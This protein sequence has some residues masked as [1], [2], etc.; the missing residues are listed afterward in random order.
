[1]KLCLIVPMY[2]W[3]F[4]KQ[5]LETKALTTSEPA[6]WSLSQRWKLSL[7]IFHLTDSVFC[8]RCGCRNSLLYFLFTTVL[9][10]EFTESSA[11]CIHYLSVSP[12]QPAQLPL[13]YFEHDRHSCAWD[14]PGWLSWCSKS[15]SLFHL[16]L[17]NNLHYTQGEANQK[18]LWD[19]MPMLS[20]WIRS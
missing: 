15:E 10:W 9:P 19:T 14:P 16:P 18:Y 4:F 12:W 5:H 17:K 11:R 2:S 6:Y 20:L 13:W 8:V 1:M 7:R 3:I